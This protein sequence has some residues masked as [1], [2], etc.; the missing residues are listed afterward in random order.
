MWLMPLPFGKAAT[1]SESVS[2]TWH[3]PLGWLGGDSIGAR[4]CLGWAYSGPSGTARSQEGARCLL[5][6]LLA[7]TLLS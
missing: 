6:C 1:S 5:Q 7:S 3:M 2:M 4:L